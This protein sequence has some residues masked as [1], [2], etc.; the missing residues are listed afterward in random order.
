MT[1]YDQELSNLMRSNSGARWGNKIGMLLLPVYY[2]RS[3]NSDPL[4]Y[5]K[6]AKLMIDK[7]KQSLE[8]HFS[9]IIGYFVMSIFGPKVHF[10]SPLISSILLRYN[11][12]D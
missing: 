3:N 11:S 5:L 6:R 1:I 12:S 2:H 4:E 8:S 10:L 7:K 9:Y